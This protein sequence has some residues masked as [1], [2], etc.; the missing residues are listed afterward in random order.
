M[1]R[2]QGIRIIENPIRQLFG[3]CRVIID[4]A[5]GSG[6]E[7][8]DQVVLLPF[9]KRKMQ[10]VFYK[11]YSRVRLGNNVYK[12]AKEVFNSLFIKSNLCTT[13]SSWIR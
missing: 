9:I 13:Y 2:V 11:N 4:S 10:F 6:D 12:G 7:K 3:Y 1:N 5:G 8:E